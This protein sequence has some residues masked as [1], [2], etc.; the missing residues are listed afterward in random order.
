MHALCISCY[1]CANPK[2]PDSKEESN[3]P[4]GIPYNL[5]TLVSPIVPSQN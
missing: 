4:L 2:M 5:H 1:I 3:N